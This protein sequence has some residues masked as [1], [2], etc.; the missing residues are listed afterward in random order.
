MYMRVKN[1][2][3]P[4]RSNYAIFHKNKVGQNWE[5][6]SNLYSPTV[7]CYLLFYIAIKTS[8]TWICNNS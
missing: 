1:L 4:E 5:K 2:V 8:L 3:G 6:K 7:L